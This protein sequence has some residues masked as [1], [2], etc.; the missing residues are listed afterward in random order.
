MLNNSTLVSAKHCMHWPYV[1]TTPMTL[2]IQ[3]FKNNDVEMNAN[4]FNKQP[5][6]KCHTHIV[7][8]KPVPDKT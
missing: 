1:Y 5:Q 8:E 6:K 7:E 4:S 2:V 3:L